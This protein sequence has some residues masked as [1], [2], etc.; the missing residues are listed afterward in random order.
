[1]RVLCPDCGKP[2]CNIQ[3]PNGYSYAQVE[4]VAFCREEQ[5][6]FSVDSSFEMV[7]RKKI[8]E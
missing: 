5:K 2:L 4:G 8:N 1:M 7:W 6:M 3:A